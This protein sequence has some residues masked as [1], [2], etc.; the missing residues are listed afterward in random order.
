MFSI[1]KGM[2]VEK[3]F[4]MIREEIRNQYLLGFSPSN[5][6]QAGTYRNLKIKMKPSQLTVQ[7]RKRYYAFLPDEQ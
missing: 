3:I 2:P 6:A 5:P 4:E 7:A 1:R